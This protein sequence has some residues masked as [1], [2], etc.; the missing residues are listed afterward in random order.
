[1]LS[2]G[3]IPP[4]SPNND[5][6]IAPSPNTIS[7]NIFFN[8][9]GTAEF[10]FTV[11]NSAGTT[12]YRFIH[13]P[14]QPPVVNNTGQV[15]TDFHFELGYGRGANFVRSGSDFLDFD[16]PERDP[17]PTSSV[18]TTLNHQDD[19]L[20]WAGGSVLSVGTV[21]FSFS[22]DVPDNL[23]N[24]NPSGLNQFT[25]RQFPTLSPIAVPEPATMLLLLTGLAGIGWKMRQQRQAQVKCAVSRGV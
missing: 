12:E 17:A 22:I 24:F 11:E 4:P 2:P 19:T 13:P 18:F 6:A 1:M 10:E 15:W 14:F 9:F 25:L 16:T 23:Q 7:Y 5:N 8:T 21:A 20:D 3:V